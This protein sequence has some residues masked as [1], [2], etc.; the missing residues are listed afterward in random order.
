MKREGHVGLALFLSSL[1]MYIFNCLSLKVVILSVIFSTF[2]DVDLRLGI[3]HRKYTHSLPIAFV[4]SILFGKFC[5]MVGIGFFQ[6]FA[7]SFIGI[8]SHIIGDLLTYRPFAP[9]Y[10]IWKRK[11]SLGLFRSDNVIANYILL[12]A[13]IATFVALTIDYFP[14]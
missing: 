3:A 10:P 6:G 2:P 8:S 13:G 12:I 7:G 1:L 5:S 14:I 4:F 9:F 11:F